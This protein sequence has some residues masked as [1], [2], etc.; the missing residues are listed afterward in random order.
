MY[1]YYKNMFMIYIRLFETSSFL[2][3]LFYCLYLCLLF[4]KA[5]KYQNDSKYSTNQHI[6]ILE[7]TWFKFHIF[8]VKIVSYEFVKI[9]PNFYYFWKNTK[10]S[11]KPTVRPN[12]FGF[13]S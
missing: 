11:L 6:T 7:E 2:F 12:L 4:A 1:L 3:I 10:S 13:D 8:L 5:K 9:K